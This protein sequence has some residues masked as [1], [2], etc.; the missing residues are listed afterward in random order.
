MM[1]PMNYEMN[2]AKQNSKG[3]WIHFCRVEIGDTL[4]EIAEAKAREI[5]EMFGKQY[6]C[7]LTRVECVGRPVQI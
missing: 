5:K 4:P 6:K 3:N 7:S 1:I 2:V